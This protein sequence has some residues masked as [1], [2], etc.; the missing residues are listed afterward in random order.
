M[1]EFSEL[2]KEPI[3]LLALFEVAE[4]LPLDL[5][6]E[7]PFPLLPFLGNG[8][9]ICVLVFERDLPDLLLELLVFPLENVDLRLDHDV[10]YKH[11]FQ[12]L[13]L[14]VLLIYLLAY[15]FP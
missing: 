9:V 11:L 2:V 14:V 3:G 8:G 5:R 7:P 6:L 15:L 13:A 1:S 10:R 12:R 4:K